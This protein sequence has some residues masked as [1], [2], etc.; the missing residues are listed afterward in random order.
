MQTQAW[1]QAAATLP[2]PLFVFSVGLLVLISV[3]GIPL[4]ITVTLLLAGALSTRMPDG[5][6]VFAALLVVV[7]L[8]TTLRDVLA[9]LLGRGG[10]HLWQRRTRK[11]S[12]C[13]ASSVTSGPII[14]QSIP[15]PSLRRGPL[16]ALWQRLRTSVT[17]NSPVLAAAQRMA[18][19]QRNLILILT[20]LS[21]LATPFD[22][23]FGMLGMTLRV[24]VPPIL[25]GRAIYS[26]LLLGAGALSGTAWQHG[27]SLPQL[28]GILSVI[29]LVLMVLPSI[30]SRRMLARTEV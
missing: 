5:G 4:P 27:A 21:P 13:I 19:Q 11:K 26:L 24:Y 14:R 9:L 25:V 15:A 30:L 29:V 8:A 23:A 17:K 18:P 2:A 3:A 22:I 1:L 6:V 12:D 16:G 28:L 7:T 10:G 20:R